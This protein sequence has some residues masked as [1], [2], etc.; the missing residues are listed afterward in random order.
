MLLFV[1]DTSGKSGFV[2]LARADERAANEVE[3]IEEASLSGG[4]FSAQLVPQIATLLEKHGLRKSDIGAFIVV[5]G[6]GSFTGLRVGLA[7]IKGLAEIL[8]KPIVAISLLEMMAL[9]GGRPGKVVAALDAGRGEVYVG[10]YEISY[11]G[12]HVLTAKVA[13]EQVVSKEELVSSARNSVVVTCSENLALAVRAE[14]ISVCHV[15]APRTHELARLGWTKLRAGETVQP[16][17]MDANYMRRSD[18]EIFVRPT[19]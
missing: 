10:E 8:H 4:A 15:E 12:A 11:D 7:A 16:D 9:A 5:S 1:T 14:G 17:Q 2:G 18:A 19:S 6:P 3:L 13:R